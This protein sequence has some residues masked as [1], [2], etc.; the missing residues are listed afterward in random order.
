VGGADPQPLK[1]WLGKDVRSLNAAPQRSDPMA[2]RYS[3]RISTATPTNQ[4]AMP[5]QQT[6]DSQQYTE[7]DITNPPP[8]QT[9]QSMQERPTSCIDLLTSF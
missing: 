1:T 8:H 9:E 7:T 6:I 5:E 3:Y 4:S 2:L